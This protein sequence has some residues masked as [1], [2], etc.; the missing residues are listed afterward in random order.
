MSPRWSNNTHA[1]ISTRRP[2]GPGS[3]SRDCTPVQLIPD[4]QSSKLVCSP[5]NSGFLQEFAGKL[6]LPPGRSALV[7]MNS[8]RGS[9]W[10]PRAVSLPQPCS[11]HSARCGRSRCKCGA[12]VRVSTRVRRRVSETGRSR[13][14]SRRETATVPAD[15]YRPG[16]LLRSGHSPPRFRGGR[17]KTRPP[18]G[19]ARWAACLFFLFL[20]GALHFD[21]HNMAFSRTQVF[22]A[23]TLRI[24]PAR[25][26][27]FEFRLLTL[28]ARSGKPHFAR[29]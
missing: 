9:T 16:N 22:Y 17:A 27:R 21:I 8:H 6:K 13:S 23:M 12:A 10:S 7:S 25:L 15:P 28:A 4:F 29:S 18:A 24:T 20:G 3:A 14:D 11:V 2:S 1:A 5:A 26:A 19:A